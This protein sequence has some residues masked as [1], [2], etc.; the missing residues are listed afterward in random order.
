MQKA[1]GTPLLYSDPAEAAHLSGRLPGDLL[2]H[3]SKI[4]RRAEFQAS[5]D[6]LH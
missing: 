5:G 1:F 4:G 2:E 3:L 6:L